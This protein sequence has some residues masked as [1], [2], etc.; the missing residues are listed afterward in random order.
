MDERTRFN[1]SSVTKAVLAIAI[2]RLESKGLLA[3][4]EAVDAHLPSSLKRFAGHSITMRQLLAHTSGVDKPG[5]SRS[6]L[7]GES[8]PS[9]EEWL[10]GDSRRHAWARCAAQADVTFCPGMSLHYSNSGVAL[11]GLVAC[12][13][14]KVKGLQELMD[15][16]LFRPLKL[17]CTFDPRCLTNYAEPV[18]R[19]DGVP[20]GAVLCYPDI[21]AGGLWATSA[22]VMSIGLALCRAVQGGGDTP[23]SRAA[24]NLL[25]EA[26]RTSAG[27]GVVCCGFDTRL[28]S[29]VWKDGDDTGFKSQVGWDV[30][31]GDGVVVLA[32]SDSDATRD[33]INDVVGLVQ[34]AFGLSLQGGPLAGPIAE[35]EEGPEAARWHGKYATA[36]GVCVI[37]PGTERGNLTAR[38]NGHTSELTWSASSRSDTFLAG[39]WGN[40][41][42]VFGES[43]FVMVASTSDY[44]V[45]ERFEKQ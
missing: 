37:G 2:A 18:P 16:V 44:P 40:A 35:P 6:Y 19:P 5:E 15:A 33:F 28:D 24:R 3:L 21:G 31:S 11:A 1:T 7:C 12:T 43:H 23:W 36:N 38:Y 9:V 45:V 27:I 39:D 20:P 42:F 30:V 8:M 22:E 32:N 25:Q 17:G 14:A 13:C 4:D 41:V 26:F 29:S 34:N 10:N